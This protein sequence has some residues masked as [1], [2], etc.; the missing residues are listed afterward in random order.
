MKKF[1]SLL[2]L[3]AGMISPVQAQ[4]ESDWIFDDT[5]LPEV[6]IYLEQDSLDLIL[7]GDVNSDHEYPATFIFKAD[8]VSDTVES[9]G[10]RLRGNTSR[11][12]QKKSFK[13][14]FN[15]F[16]DGREYY[17][18]DKIN[19]N[20]EHNDPS[21]MRTKLSWDFIDYADIPGSRVNHVKLYINDTYFGLYMNVEH[22]DDEFV[23]D[24]FATDEGNLYKCLWPADLT[25]RGSS[26][27]DYKW[28]ANGQSRRTY[29]LKTNEAEDNYSDLAYLIYFL[30]TATEQDFE[31]RIENILNVDGVLRWMAI[32]IL[33]GSWDDYWYNKNNYYLYKN[34]NTAQFEFIPYDYDNTFGIW[35]DGIES[36]IDWG[37]RDI[38]NWG[39]T[40]EG[41]PLTERILAVDKYRDRLHFY[42]NKFIDEYFNE[43]NLFPEID[44]LKTLT[45]VAAEEDDYRTFDYGWD[46]DDYHASFTSAL[47][48][49]VTY[50]LKPYI[51]T[52]VNSALAQIDL[53]DIVPAFRNTEYDLTESGSG[54]QFELTTEVVDEADPQVTINYLINGGIEQIAILSD[55]GDGHFSSD[56]SIDIENITTF[57]FYLEATDSEMQTGRYPNDPA[58][59]AIIEFEQFSEINTVIINEFLADNETGIQDENGSFEDWIELFNP[60]DGAINLSGYFLTDDFLSPEKW[61]LPDTTIQ[62]GEYL[63][64][65][66][67]NDDEEGPLH[68]NFGLSNDGEEVGLFYKDVLETV[69]ADTITFGP[70]SDDISYGRVSDGATE[71][72]FFSSP[73]PGSSNSGGVSNEPE[74]EVPET[75]ILHQ[76]YPNPFN[77]NTMIRFQLPVSSEVSLKVFDML[78]REVETLV[79]GRMAAGEHTI[80]FNAGSLSSGVYFYRLSTGE[81]SVTKKFTLLK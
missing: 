75:L 81:M 11:Y 74:S 12:S 79:N 25:Y 8:A 36:G 47:D 58:R 80:S 5:T 15:T 39:K 9:I 22:I 46:T 72:I 57:S 41:R 55:D 1:L 27:D 10:F 76:N 60:T 42:I 53:Q 70:Q 16:V 73:T 50:G 77:P 44:R 19:L 23:D 35:W 43:T 49:H 24:R 48:G 6:R 66:A 54:Y 4:S 29:E 13:V 69:I 31:N 78:G 28:I 30:E 26:Q 52:R 3:S 14:S 40:N 56:L 33:T 21:I 45:E 37:T 38:D 18:L 20:G 64:I 17:G 61:A 34:P 2:L 71:F 63:V 51:A 62:P 32:D 7:N 59:S 65:W 67:D 68:T